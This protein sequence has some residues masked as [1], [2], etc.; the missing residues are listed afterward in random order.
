MMMGHNLGSRIFSAYISR[1]SRMDMQ[2]MTI[3]Q[4]EQR[5]LIESCESICS[6][7]DIPCAVSKEGRRAEFDMGEAKI[8]TQA[9]EEA[10]IAFRANHLDLSIAEGT[11]LKL[12]EVI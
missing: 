8:L 12:P 2:K 6:A 4:V 7:Y 1:T 3:G 10:R 5:E 9:F 11:R